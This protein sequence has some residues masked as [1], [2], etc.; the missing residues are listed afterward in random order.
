[1]RHRKRTF[2]INRTSSHRRAMM[3]NMACS[4]IME[5]QIKTTTVRAKELRRIVEKLITLGKRGSL[6]ARRQAIAFLRHP[7]VARHLFTNI[8]PRFSD[9][10]GGYT[11][12]VKL[13]N[14]IGDGAQLC[15]IEILNEPCQPRAKKA[16]PAEAGTEDSAGT[17]AAEAA[18]EAGAEVAAEEAAEDAGG[19]AVAE[20]GD[21]QTTAEAPAEPVAEETAAES[22]ATDDEKAGD[23]EDKP[24]AE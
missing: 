24:K 8:A 1:M 9:R 2:K 22:T 7:P 18:A 3:A 20:E 14:R 16:K 10:N 21:A 13:P 23:E 4:L 11:R 6:H 12:I 5:G 15:M 17:A 19:V